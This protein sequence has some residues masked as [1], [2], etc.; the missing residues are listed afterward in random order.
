[1]D[2][3]INLI[4]KIEKLRNIMH[5]LIAKEGNLLHFKVIK[6]SQDLDKLL[7]EYNRIVGY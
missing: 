7:N 2:K 5:D 4:V 3:E 1:M 6:V